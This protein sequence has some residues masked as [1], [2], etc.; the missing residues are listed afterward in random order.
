MIKFSY[1]A[2]GEARICI[3]PSAR[4]AECGCIA[5]AMTLLHFGFP[6][7]IRIVITDW[8]TD[9]VIGPMSTRDAEVMSNWHYEGRWSVY[10]LDGR[11]PAVIDAY[12]SV[13]ACSGDGDLIGFYCTGEEARV[14]GVGD[15]DGTVD[16]GWGMNPAWVGQ[17]HG[18]SFGVA[19]LQEVRQLHD[20]NSIRAFVQSWNQRSIRVLN[21]L[22]FTRSMIYTCIQR[23][24]PVRYDVLILA[25]Y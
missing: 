2:A 23:G 11:I 18:Q 16:L 22:G 21:R 25:P 12:R 6:T 14:L 5:F 24:Q 7:R 19:V 17:R 15:V 8:R 9:L 4:P 3:S 20:G 10:D 13:R 1:G